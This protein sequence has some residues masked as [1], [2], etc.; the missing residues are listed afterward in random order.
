M[1]HLTLLLSCIL[2]SSFLH[3]QNEIGTTKSIALIIANETYIDPNDRLTNPVADGKAVANCLENLGYKVIRA[4]N[5]NHEQ[6]LASIEMFTQLAEHYDIALFYYTGHGSQ[7]R[8]PNG[9][10]ENYLVPVN[11]TVQSNEDVIGRCVSLSKVAEGL[12]NPDGQCKTKLLFIDACRDIPTHRNA[13]R[14]AATEYNDCCTFFATAAGSVADDGDGEHSPFTQAWLDAMQIPGLTLGTLF[15]KL[16]SNISALTSG[17]QKATLLCSSSSDIILVPDK[18]KPSNNHK[19]INTPKTDIA[20]ST[21]KQAITLFSKQQYQEAVQLFLKAAEYGSSDANGALGYCYYFGV[22]VNQDYEEA[23]FHYRQAAQK[24][25]DYAQTGLGLCYLHGK[26]VEKDP[27]K[28]AQWFMQA[29]IQGDDN[30]EYFIGICY[31]LGYGIEKNSH[32]AADW[33]L[34]AAEQG[35]SDAQDAIADCFMYGAGIEKNTETAMQ[36]YKRAAQAGNEHA[37]KMLLK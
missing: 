17:E 11:V 21:Y 2:L 1:K 6:M 19:E 25:I 27:K 12:D 8:L 22:G 14:V 28:A 32:L 36:W 37:Q 9:G 20:S 7:G 5:K 16:S 35:N 23:V 3:A 15:P 4:Y 18:N 29:A 34:K 31:S 33:F 30:A 10:I 26:G 24:G 13:R